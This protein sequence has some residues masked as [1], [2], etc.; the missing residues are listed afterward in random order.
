MILKEQFLALFF[1]FFFGV[2][3]SFLYNFNYNLLF[4]KRMGIKVFFTIV[5]ILDMVL[6]YFFV[7]EKINGGIVHFSFYFFIL[8]GVVFSYRKGVVLRKYIKIKEKKKTKLMPKS[9]NKD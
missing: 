2:V 3:L 5:F 6:I 7:I 4:T 8:G 9:V 1:S